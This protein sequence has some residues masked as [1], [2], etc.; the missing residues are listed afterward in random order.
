MKADAALR[1]TAKTGGEKG[2]SVKIPIPKRPSTTPPRPRPGSR[3]RKLD[4]ARGGIKTRGSVHA[5]RSL[6]SRGGSV[7]MT[8]LEMMSHKMDEADEYTRRIQ[9]QK[10]DV[11]RN[12]RVVKEYKLKMLQIQKEISS[13]LSDKTMR[14]KAGGAAAVHRWENKLNTSSIKHSKAK[15]TISTIKE[16][17][18]NARLAQVEHKKQ[19]KEINEDYVNAQAIIVDHEQRIK[20]AK[21]AKVAAEERTKQVQLAAEEEAVAFKKKLQELTE[22]IDSRTEDLARTKAATQNSDDQSQ[23]NNPQNTT[24]TALS[25]FMGSSMSKFNLGALSMQQEE[26][27]TSSIQK[28]RWLLGTSG[29]NLANQQ[30]RAQNYER[31]FKT[32]M[33][34]T[35]LSS[36]KEIV[37]SFITREKEYF[38]L[39][40]HAQNIERQMTDL[41]ESIAKVQ[42]GFAAVASGED[43]TAKHVTTPHSAPQRGK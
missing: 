4:E 31:A 11:S 34:K 42:V 37:N 25:G 8:P 6:T 19:W 10:R 22:V 7:Y 18:N 24:M 35:G 41:R 20:D 3:A 28:N 32:L 29:I 40:K 39:Y 43:N 33:E 12:D 13:Y 16:K 21:A 38:N 17:I 14:D 5:G 23:D 27:I 30:K 2:G 1:A 15:S 26:K 36:V 9:Q